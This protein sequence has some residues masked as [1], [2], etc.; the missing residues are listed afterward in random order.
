MPLLPIDEAIHAYRTLRPDEAKLH[1]LEIQVLRQINA[2]NASSLA[3]WLEHLFAPQHRWASAMAVIAVSFLSAS[4]ML[5][6][7]NGA[8]SHTAQAL[9]LN[10][11]SPEYATPLYPILK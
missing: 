6:T 1:E 5:G 8:T 2:G 11:F 4:M 3:N 10:V 9:G 7:P